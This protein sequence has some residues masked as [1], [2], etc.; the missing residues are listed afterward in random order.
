[1]TLIAVCI[2]SACLFVCTLFSVV[3]AGDYRVMWVVTCDARHARRRRR[4]RRR[5]TLHGLLALTRC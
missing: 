5:V 4:R 1:M 2:Y 3:V